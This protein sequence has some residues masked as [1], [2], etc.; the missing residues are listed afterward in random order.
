MTFNGP[1]LN[2]EST[3]PTNLTKVKHE[4]LSVSKLK[5]LSE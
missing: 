5:V 4:F 3:G 1:S 2:D